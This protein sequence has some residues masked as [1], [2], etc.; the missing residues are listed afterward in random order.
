MSIGVFH[1]EGVTVVALESLSRKLSLSEKAVKQVFRTDQERLSAQNFVFRKC[2][3]SSFSGPGGIPN[4]FR[5]SSLSVT[6]RHESFDIP[7]VF[8]PR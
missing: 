2:K 4:V 7:V 3:Y 8:Q 1:S 5:L 6:N